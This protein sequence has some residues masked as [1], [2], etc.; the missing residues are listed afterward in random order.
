MEQSELL[1]V[2]TVDSFDNLRCLPAAWGKDSGGLADIMEVRID[3]P[4][5]SK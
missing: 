1:C 4:G 5:V 3:L 2:R